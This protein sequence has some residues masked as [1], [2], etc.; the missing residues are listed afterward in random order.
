VNPVTPEREAAEHRRLQGAAHEQRDRE[1][2]G[3]DDEQQQRRRQQR[4]LGR[5][6][7]AGV[8]REV[9]RRRASLHDPLLPRY[10]GLL[11]CIPTWRKTV[12]N[13]ELSGA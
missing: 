7:A 1:L 5:C 2:E 13:V 8:A 10:A 4:E 6:L 11:S 12:R 9:D 3:A